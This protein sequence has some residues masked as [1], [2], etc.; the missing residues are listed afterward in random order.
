M[1]LRAGRIYPEPSERWGGCILTL[2]WRCPIA[3]GRHRSSSYRPRGLGPQRLEI[4]PYPLGGMGVGGGGGGRFEYC[5]RDASSLMSE[6]TG[7]TSPSGTPRDASIVFP[8]SDRKRERGP[9]DASEAARGSSVGMRGRNRTEGRPNG[10]ERNGTKQN[11]AEQSRAERNATERNG[12]EGNTSTPSHRAR[13]EGWQ[14]IWDAGRSARCATHQSRPDA[15]NVVNDVPLLR[16]PPKEGGAY[17]G[18]VEAAGATGAVDRS[19]LFLVRRLSGT[20]GGGGGGEG[21]CMGNHVRPVVL[22]EKA[23][24]LRPRLGYKR[25]VH[26]IEVLGPLP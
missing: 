23:S 8:P 3:F 17:R 19:S 20:G 26:G 11:R 7:V 14:P 22:E 10:T 21:G 25:L 24:E 18:A 9:T 15:A 2:G 13:R 1:V 12:D 16:R 4:G 6:A 5:V